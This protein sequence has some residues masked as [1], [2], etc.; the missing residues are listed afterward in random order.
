MTHGDSNNKKGMRSISQQNICSHA[1]NLCNSERKNHIEKLEQLRDILSAKTA[2]VD[3]ILAD[4]KSREQLLLTYTSPNTS[5]WLKR[6]AKEM[7]HPQLLAALEKFA[8]RPWCR[9]EVLREG[10]MLIFVPIHLFYILLRIICNVQ[11]IYASH[12]LNMYTYISVWLG[13]KQTPRSRFMK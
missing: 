12:W 7:F 4:V 5:K 8:A 9:P 6:G 10:K 3:S 2:Q 11:Y 13:N 1:N